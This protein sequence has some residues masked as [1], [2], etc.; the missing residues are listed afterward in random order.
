MKK[1]KEIEK[2][3]T[4]LEEDVEYKDVHFEE[5]LNLI[6]KLMVDLKE[7]VSKG[8]QEQQKIAAEKLEQARHLL[9]DY[10]ESATEKLGLE[11]DQLQLILSY[12]L[13]TASPHRDK[14][15]VFQQE[16]EKNTEEVEKLLDAKI[17]QKKKRATLKKYAQKSSWVQS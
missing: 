10:L 4:F 11:Q 16:F 3:E 9:Y 8:S 17:P 5:L 12:F 13:N 6:N 2:I 1:N 14:L 7:A 15:V